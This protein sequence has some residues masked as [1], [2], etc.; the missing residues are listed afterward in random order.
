MAF[1]FSLQGC[2]AAGKTTALKYVEKNNNFID[3]SY[4]WD[5]EIIEK[6]K[7]K[8]LDKTNLRDYI[9]VQRM[10]IEKEISRYNRALAS[11]CT[12]MDFG[13]EEIEFS[14]LYWPKTIGM[15]WDIENIMHNELV[16]LRK[17]M[18]NRILFL[19]ASEEKL[20][21]NKASDSKRSRSYFEY[22]F[23]RLL[24]LKKEWA[25]KLDNLDYL[26]VDN[27]TEEQVGK[28]VIEWVAQYYEA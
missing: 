14:T 9:E 12:V 15:D 10:W 25:K 5:N 23:N 18:P 13:A 3:A 7:G 2:M 27:M 6:L 22:Y 17:C 8:N 1:I 4:E 21:A 16:Q 24:P 19:D 20:R 11:N 26:N 28:K